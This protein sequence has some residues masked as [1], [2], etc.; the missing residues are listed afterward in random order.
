MPEPAK[1]RRGRPDKAK[2]V[3][4]YARLH[5]YL[6]AFAEG[7]LNLLI[8]VGEA[9]IAKSRTVVAPCSAGRPAGSRAT[10]RPSACTKSFIGI[11][12]TS[13]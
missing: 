6:R 5:E 9:G 1:R 2:Y 3:A 8:L 10:P 4:T 12:T 7:H 13:S 11:G